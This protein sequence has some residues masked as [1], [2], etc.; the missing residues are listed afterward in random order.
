MSDQQSQENQQQ[1][2]PVTVQVPQD[3]LAKRIEEL[4]KLAD[5]HLN[6]WKRAKADLINFKREVEEE[7]KQWMTFAFMGAVIRF[8]PILDHLYAALEAQEKLE[9]TDEKYKNFIQG[10]ENTKRE[11]EET[12]RQMKVTEVPGVGFEFDPLVHE[13]VEKE[14]EVTGKGT[15]MVAR[16]V[17]RGYKIEEQLIRPAKVVIKEIVEEGKFKE[18]NKFKD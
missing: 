4:Q 16:V 18:F 6:G 1:D 12:L 11:F 10:I 14:G 2:Q 13:S 5:D 3:D 8:L 17:K 15:L 7:K 9:S